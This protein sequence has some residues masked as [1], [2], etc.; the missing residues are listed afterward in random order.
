VSSVKSIHIPV[1]VLLSLASVAGVVAFHEAGHF[2][3]AKWQGMKIDSYNIGYG[4]KV[5]SFNDSTNTEFALR[6]VPLGGYVAFP[7]NVEYDDESG[8]IVRTLDDPDL[9]QNRPPLQRAIVISAG[10]V[11]NVLLSFL[12]CTGVSLSTGIGTPVY[13]QGVVISQI[14][15]TSSP[16]YRSGLRVSDII[17]EVNHRP[18]EASETAVEQFVTTVRRQ[19]ESQPLDLQIRRYSNPLAM[20]GEQ[21]M[22]VQVIPEPNSKGKMSIGVG[23]NAMV[24]E[25]KNIKATNPIEAVTIGAQ[26]TLKLILFTW[27]AFTRAISTGFSGNEVGGPIAVVKAGAQM[28]EY[29]PS[30]LIGFIASLSI[31]LAVLNSLPFPALDGGQLS[32]VLVE[33]LLGRPIPRRIQDSIT[34]VAFSVILVFG[35]GT[36]IGDIDRLMVSIPAINAVQLD[37]TMMPQ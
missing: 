20:T 33:S 30:A 13:T 11:A 29:S 35:V 3:A 18:I 34:A 8:E 27:N 28:A 5:L 25:V 22:D 32:F 2:L 9:I 17:T 26:Q 6:L 4:P 31:N 7:T 37:N 24:K 19:S 14:Y 10:V 16:A 15:D 23:I 12:I 36:I 21:L 1:N